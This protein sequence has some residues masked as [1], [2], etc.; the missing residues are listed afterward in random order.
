MKLGAPAVIATN[1]IGLAVRIA[2]KS[3][4]SPMGVPMT[5]VTANGLPIVIVSSRGIP[6]FLTDTAGNEYVP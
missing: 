5:V 1:G 2:K 3:D 4:N 6:V